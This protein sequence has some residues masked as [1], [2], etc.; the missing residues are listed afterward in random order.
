MPPP[1]PSAQL[2]SPIQTR[3]FQNRPSL[4]CSFL[5]G[6]LV[7]GRRQAFAS[8]SSFCATS[9]RRQDRSWRG[10]T[11]T[12][13][14]RSKGRH[15]KA[16]IR[17]P[18]HKGLAAFHG[19]LSWLGLMKRSG[20]HLKAEKGKNVNQGLELQF[21]A[22]TVSLPRKQS[23]AAPCWSGTPQA[24]RTIAPDL[25]PRPSRWR[26]SIELWATEVYPGVASKAR[27]HLGGV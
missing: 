18:E 10:F 2:S 23:C 13:L 12:C 11:V 27:L 8:T 20:P 9:S 21:P 16:H 26:G 24:S 19:G 17:G 15:S 25:I 5:S 14:N 6:A 3:A 4:S 22:P 7:V 1:D